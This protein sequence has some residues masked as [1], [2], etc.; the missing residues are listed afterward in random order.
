LEPVPPKP[1]SF[2]ASTTRS[3]RCTRAA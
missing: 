1:S 2:P 3:C